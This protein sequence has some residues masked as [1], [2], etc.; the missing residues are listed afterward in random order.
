MYI[1]IY[2]YICKHAEQMSWFSYALANWKH[3]QVRIYVHNTCPFELVH[4]MHNV[5]QLLRD[6]LT[7][8]CYEQGSWACWM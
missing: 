7:D 8:M 4:I 5:S 1:Y 2:I 6:E 3:F